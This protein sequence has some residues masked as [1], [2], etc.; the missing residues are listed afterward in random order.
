M[1][2]SLI[3]AILALATTFSPKL[4]A[5]S[6]DAGMSS[7]ETQLRD[8]RYQSAVLTYVYGTSG[9][10]GDSSQRD[11]RYN[12]LVLSGES[13]VFGFNVWGALPINQQNG[14]L[15]SVTGIGDLMVVVDRTLFSLAGAD[16]SVGIGGRFATASVNQGGLPQAYQ[17][18]VGSNDYLI[19]ANAM[20]K[21]LNF[22]IAYQLSGNRNANNLT[23]LKQGDQFVLRGGYTYRGDGYDVGLQLLAI[24]QIQLTSVLDPLSQ[25]KSF[26]DVA[27]TDKIHLDILLKGRYQ[28]FG[29]LAATASA[30]FP[31]DLRDVNVDGLTREFTASIGA[32]VDL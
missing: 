30:G 25:T 13:E 8:P 10:S 7:T 4:F 19:Q 5:Q 23:Q 20:S 32:A 28:V 15:G 16:F 3:V 26:M 18:G 22:G 27:G 21:S 12:S 14:L 6:S 31:I 24:K 1:K 2:R 9:P 29:W 11:I 17:S